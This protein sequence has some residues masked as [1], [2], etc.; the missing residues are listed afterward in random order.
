MTGAPQHDPSRRDDAPAWTVREGTEKDYPEAVRVFCE[1]L[2]LSAREILD[3]ERDHPT[4]EHDRTLLAVDGDRVVGTALSHGFEMTMP[5][6]PRRVAGVSGVGVWPTYRRR[7][8]LS[9]LMRRQLAEVRDR[10]ENL[11]ALWASEGGIYARFGYGLAFRETNA[12]LQRA[13]ARLR[14]DAPRDPSLT[15][16][17]AETA[18][19]RQEVERVYR[20]ALPQRAGQLARDEHWWS[21]ILQ[22][23]EA[24]GP[25]R[26]RAALVR[27]PDGPL[28]YALYRVVNRWEDGLASGR[29]VV[30]ELASV[31]TAA[32]VALYEH[33]LDRDLTSEAVFEKLPGD[34]PLTV[35]LADPRRLVRRDF[36][37]LWMRLVDLPGAL[38]DRPYATPVDTVLEV[39]DRYAPW[40]AGRWRLEADTGGARVRP[41]DAAPDLALDASH[42]GAAYLGGRTLTAFADAG[43]LTEHVPG[44]AARLDTALHAPRAPF[45]GTDF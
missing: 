32:R 6:G 13:H 4:T 31:S 24:G 23:K 40:N 26:L 9:A 10:G 29:V 15:L 36:D 43:L 37:A 25:G 7:G 11:A 33:L 3:N 1:A 35:L 8:V 17:L 16:E 22:D 39:A 27:G 18:E 44:A 2:N 45:C 20:E 14:P 34:D 42:L 41:T 21:L 5:G 38:S 30:R 28:G 12:T 19:V